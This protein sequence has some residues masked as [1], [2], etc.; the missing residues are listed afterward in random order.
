MEQPSGVLWA[1]ATVADDPAGTDQ[2]LRL[3]NQLQTGPLS[4]GVTQPDV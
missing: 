1:V 3:V 4:S 2:T